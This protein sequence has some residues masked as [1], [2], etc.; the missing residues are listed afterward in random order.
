MSVWYCFCSSGDTLG[1]A[2][3]KTLSKIGQTSV[4]SF[5][6]TCVELGGERIC[7]SDNPLMMKLRRSHMSMFANSA[8]LGG[9]VRVRVW[10]REQRK[11]KRRSKALLSL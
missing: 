4:P 5:W 3:F 1:G 8:L 9:G 6:E 2:A 11:I 10:I 7:G